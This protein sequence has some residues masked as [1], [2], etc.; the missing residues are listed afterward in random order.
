[1]VASGIVYAVIFPFVVVVMLREIWA[2]GWFIPHQ[3]AA[4]AV[5]QPTV[6]EEPSASEPITVAKILRWTIG[7]AGVIGFASGPIEVKAAVVGFAAI[8]L[9]VWFWTA[10]DP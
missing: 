6:R 3:E 10:F 2:K 4:L 8:W 1:V 7:V 5:R 9:L